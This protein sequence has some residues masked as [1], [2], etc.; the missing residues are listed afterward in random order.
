[1]S[2]GRW[3]GIGQDG[4]TQV[5]S[6]E[7]RTSRWTSRWTTGGSSGGTSGSTSKSLFSWLLRG[8]EGMTQV[9]SEEVRNSKWTSRWT[10]STGGPQGVL[11]LQR[12]LHGVESFQM[13]SGTGNMGQ[14]QSG[15]V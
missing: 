3:P 15:L 10:L 2:I 14:E 7:V 5:W 13:D 9:W 11:Q 6:E 4:M 8:L 12:V 1:M